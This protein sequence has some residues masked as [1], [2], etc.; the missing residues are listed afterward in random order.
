MEPFFANLLNHLLRLHQDIAKALAGLPQDALDWVPSGEM[1]SLAVLVAHTAGAERYWVGDVAGQQPSD[2]DRDAEFKVQGL[3]EA[4]LRQRLAEAEACARDVLASLTLADLDAPR[5]VPR[6]GRQVTVGE[7]LTHTLEH[8][9]THLGHVQIVRQ[10]WDKW[11]DLPEWLPKVEP[12][13][14]PASTVTLREV[15]AENLF[16]ILK[17]SNALTPPQKHMVATN[18]GSVAEAHYAA[19]AWYRA[20]YADETPVGFLMLH[21][22]ADGWGYFLWRLMVAVPYQRMGFARRAVELLIE[23]V[24][25]RPGAKTLGVSC[26]LGL[27]S[28]EGFYHRLGFER[29]GRWFDDEIGL[30]VELR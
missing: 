13:V 3:D 9:G 15:T 6:D 5:T 24:K 22:S 19:N 23:Y 16:D 10:M 8:T 25:T 12:T 2:R 4:A 27:G 14:T 20:I 28:P 29:D 11:A 30:S 7:A 1:N 17:L 21:D 26:G 18:A